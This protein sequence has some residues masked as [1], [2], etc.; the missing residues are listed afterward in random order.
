MTPVPTARL[1]AAELLKVR[2][3]WLPYILLLVLVALLA[4]DIW[5]GGYLS[6]R[7]A[8]DPQIKSDSLRIFSLP[9]S[10]PGILDTAQY[11]G[12]ILIAILAASMV[13]TEHGW[14]T[15]RLAL[16]RGQTRSG[17]L[18]TKLLSITV[19]G[20]IGFLLALG[21][22]IGYSVIA[23][24]VADRPITLDLPSG[25]GPS[26]LDVALMALRAAYAVLPY[27][28][29]AFCLAVV[30]RSTTLGVVGVLLFVIVEAIVVGILGGIGG[31]TADARGFLL[32]HNIVALLAANQVGFARVDSLAF[33]DS[34]PAS[35]LPDPT[36]AALVLALYCAI[37]LAI[38][39][40]TFQRRDLG[41]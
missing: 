3:R 11:W 26:V 28:L 1:L 18:T 32:S 13:A 4:L 20:A 5:L 25:D 2:K 33:R 35:E 38:A 22:G 30:G 21:V 9:W 16:I 10:L 17:Y 23:T 8:D 7:L 15:V 12:A 39:Y 37:F 19:I 29:L 40:W 34:P 27:V 41:A 36:V 14:G 6:W 31:T 24:A